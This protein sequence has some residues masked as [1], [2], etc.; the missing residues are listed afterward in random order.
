MNANHGLQYP[1]ESYKV[2][3]SFSFVLYRVAKFFYVSSASSYD[4]INSHPGKL[5][6]TSTTEIL[7][8]CVTNIGT[9]ILPV[10]W[11]NNC[12]VYCH[13]GFVQG[14]RI[15]SCTFSIHFFAPSSLVGF[16]N[17]SSFVWLVLHLY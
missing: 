4:V 3:A 6:L 7:N 10:H 1:L 11:Q 15:N 5:A 13:W 14:K 16:N 8:G 12:G 9:I 17:F 2:L